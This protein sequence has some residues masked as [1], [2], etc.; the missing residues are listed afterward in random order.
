MRRDKGERERVSSVDR[1]PGI[2]IW[3]HDIEI[4]A[5]VRGRDGGI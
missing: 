5:Y 2:L 4:L 1:R 3:Y